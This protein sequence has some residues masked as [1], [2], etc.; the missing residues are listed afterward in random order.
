MHRIFNTGS[1]YNVVAGASPRNMDE[2]IAHYEK[3]NAEKNEKTA[4]RMAERGDK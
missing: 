4:K 3:V 1:P 2:L